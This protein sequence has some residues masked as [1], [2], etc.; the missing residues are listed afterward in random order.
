MRTDTKTRQY[1]GDR[2]KPVPGGRSSG[3]QKP[4][5][6]TYFLELDAKQNPRVKL[7]GHCKDYHSE[8]AREQLQ[9]IGS[10]GL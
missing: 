6:I 10:R 2:G 5:T 8:D 3:T 4:K 9:F 1:F 7:K